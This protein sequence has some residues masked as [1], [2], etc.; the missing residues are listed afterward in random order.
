M[1]GRLAVELTDRCGNSTS[2][3]TEV[4]KEEEIFRAIFSE[5]EEKRLEK[6]RMLIEVELIERDIKEDER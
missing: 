3:S 6:M 5:E 2:K 4:D 1:E